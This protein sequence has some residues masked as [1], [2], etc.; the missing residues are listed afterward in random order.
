M[1]LPL[2]SERSVP[3]TGPG[4][5]FKKHNLSVAAVWRCV[6]KF[7]ICARVLIVLHTRI[8]RSWPALLLICSLA[9][10]ADSDYVAE[11][12]KWRADFDADVRTGGWLT[13]IGRFPVSEGITTIGSD[14]SRTVRLPSPLSRNRLGTLTR[15]GD[16]FQFRAAPDAKADLDGHPVVVKTRLSTK[17][18]M[19]RVQMGNLRLS[20]R[21]VGDD[22]YLLVADMQNP[23][24][25]EFKGTTWFP[26]DSSY[27]IPATFTSYAE[28]EKVRISMTHV[29]SKTLMTST[30]EVT[31]QL[32][33]KTVSLKSFVDDNELFIMFQDATNANETY[34]GGRFLH[35]PLPTDGATVLDFN[36]AFSPYCSLNTFIMC[37]IPPPENRLDIRVVAGETYLSHE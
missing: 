14:P 28:P 36:K 6:I 37:P 25:Q 31:F 15:H 18:G 3:G 24:I 5:E 29:E 26:I 19:G 21:S 35:A 9:S 16:G 1:A 8:I 34:G 11:I 30:G 13:L 4:S 7:D 27:R 23:A 17:P 22:F 10:A 2:S 20:V 12:Q 32:A 33:G